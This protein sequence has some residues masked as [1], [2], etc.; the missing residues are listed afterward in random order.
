MQTERLHLR[1]AGAVEAA[2]VADY[3]RRN[4]EFLAPFEPTRGEP[5]FQAERW[6]RATPHRWFLCLKE[7]PERVVGTVHLSQLSPEPFLAGYLGFSLDQR[8]QGRGLM[9]EALERVVAHAFEGLGLH[10]IMANHLPENLRS[11]RLLEALGFEKEGFARD[12]LRIQGRWRDHVLRALVNHRVEVT[13]PRGA[14]ELNFYQKRLRRVPDEVFRETGLETLILAENLLVEV[15]PEIG[16][17][18]YLRMLDL[19]HNYL[20]AVPSELG[21]LEGLDAFLYLHD[22]RL[23]DLPSALGKL[24]RLRYLNIGEN[25][26]RRIPDS[27]AQLESLVELRIGQ[28]QLVELPDGLGELSH[29]EELHL[30]GN[31]LR[32][33]PAALVRLER[34]EYLDLRGNPLAA[35]PDWVGDLSGLRRL[36]LRWTGLGES[37]A[38]ARLRSKGCRIYM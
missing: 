10:R 22:N 11:E 20:R 7:D 36:D 13:V 2:Q 28:N 34:L 21:D 27:V 16:G 6:R 30:R 23:T 9:R 31:Q 24:R 4:R 1:A 15:P 8:M 33:L 25:R 29:L 19:G 18:K 3:F 14:R 32:S 12:Y 26:L 5:Y 35:L 17:L 37:P 38:L